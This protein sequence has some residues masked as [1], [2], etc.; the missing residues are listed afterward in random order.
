VRSTTE[1]K[2]KGRENRFVQT[3][4]RIALSSSK[5]KIDDACPGGKRKKRGLRKGRK[6][7]KLAEAPVPHQDKLLSKEK[8]TFQTF[9]KQDIRKKKRE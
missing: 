7:G 9:F 2:K 6:E 4:K 3:R 1:E 8:V 5:R